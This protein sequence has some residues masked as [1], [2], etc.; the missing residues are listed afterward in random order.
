MI[1]RSDQKV[2]AQGFFER[3]F[4]GKIAFT[5]QWRVSGLT[6]FGSQNQ[7]FRSIPEGVRKRYQ[8]IKNDEVAPSIQPLLGLYAYGSEH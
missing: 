5:D 3:S 7:A 4:F 6:G 1:V 8:L 2:S